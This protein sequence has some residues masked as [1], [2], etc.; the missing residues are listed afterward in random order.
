MRI[1]FLKKILAPSQK[2]GIMRV[3][4]LVEARPS[5]LKKNPIINNLKFYAGKKIKK[6]H[7]KRSEKSS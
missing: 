4:N 6:T 1:F 2:A 7:K 3:R 5:I